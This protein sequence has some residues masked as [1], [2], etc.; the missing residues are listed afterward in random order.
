[1]IQL[2]K[3]RVVADREDVERWNIEFREKHCVVLPKLLESPLLDFLLERLAQGQWRDEAHEDIGVEVVLEDAPARGLLHFVANAPGFLKTVQ[4]I[5]GCGPLTQF[6]GRIYRFV[7]NSGHYDSWHNDNSNGRLV[8]MSLNLSPRGY[9]GGVFQL[10]EWSSKRILTEIAN[11]GW[12]DATL[13]RI[14]RQLEHRVTEVTG[15]KSKTAFAG[16]FKSGDPNPFA[17]MSGRCRDRLCTA[18]A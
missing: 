15:E 2:Q 4:E 14:S 13:F 11:T 3:S 17:E 9:E 8:A 5:T 6:G 16:W 18:D 12:G 1:M 10:R 7:P